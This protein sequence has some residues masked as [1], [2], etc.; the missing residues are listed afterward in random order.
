MRDKPL[1]HYAIE[2]GADGLPTSMAWSPEIQAAGEEAARRHS[3]QKEAA[4]RASRNPMQGYLE[5]ARA[6]GLWD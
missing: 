6:H 2:Y 4:F 1:I 5:W 3:E